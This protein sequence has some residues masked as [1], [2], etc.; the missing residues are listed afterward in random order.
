MSSHSTRT[1]TPSGKAAQAK[2]APKAVP[3][4]ATPAKV[5]SAKGT[6]KAKATR[7]APQP[8]PACVYI[9]PE[10]VEDEAE[11]VDEDEAAKEED[12]HGEE[13]DMDDDDVSYISL[14]TND[15]DEDDDKD[16]EVVECAVQ[17]APPRRKATARKA[18]TPESPKIRRSLKKGEVP[19]SQESPSPKK[20]K[21]AITRKPTFAVTSAATPSKKRAKEAYSD[22]DSEAEYRRQAKLFTD[23][24]DESAEGSIAHVTEAMQDVHIQ[25]PNLNEGILDFETP[26]TMCDLLRESY[27]S[28]P[29]LQPCTIDTGSSIMSSA[30]LHDHIIDGPYDVHPQALLDLVMF[31]HDEKADDPFIINPA[32]ADPARA[33]A[34]QYSNWKGFCMAANVNNPTPPRLICATLVVCLRCHIIEPMPMATPPV[35]MIKEFLGVPLRGELECS[36]AFYGTVFGR[37][38]LGVPNFGAGIGEHRQTSLVFRTVTNTGSRATLFFWVVGVVLDRCVMERVC[39]VPAAPWGSQDEAP[40]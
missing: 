2:A 34:Y 39:P 9:C 5:T 36:I 14:T 3:S 30:L 19:V 38:V 16:Y 18:P 22:E 31:S 35:R 8:T 29:V 11:E 24:M 25:E 15:E 27:K 26:D 1:C 17:K 37:E 40:P 23:A 10:I 6:T 4:K 28:L 21:K 13:D 7:A 32:C 33:R 12:D 20:A